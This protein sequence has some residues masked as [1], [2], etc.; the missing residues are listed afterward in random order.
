MPTIRKILVPVD[1]SD[2]SRSAAS[3]AIE[4]AEQLAAGDASV[5]V[6]AL[7]AWQLAGFATPTSELAKDTERQLRAELDG[8]LGELGAKVPVR[9]HLRLGVPYQ[10]IVQAA[11]EYESDLVIMGTTGKTGLEH[12]LIGSVAERVVRAAPVPVL[13]VRLPAR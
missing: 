9:S 2:A 12:F 8:F 13:T 5:S 4:L 10:E 11:K 3:Y 6:D 1:F 7:H